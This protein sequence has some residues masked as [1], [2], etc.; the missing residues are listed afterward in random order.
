MCISADSAHHARR[1]ITGAQRGLKIRG[2]NESA[3]SGP[4]EWHNLPDITFKLLLTYSSFAIHKYFRGDCMK[5][6]SL[7]LTEHHPF[8]EFSAQTICRA[9]TAW[10]TKELT[11]DACTE[12][13]RRRHLK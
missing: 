7:V 5:D 10:L 9:V 11:K 12:F 4:G 1:R 8:A 13:C 3:G 6:F 2:L